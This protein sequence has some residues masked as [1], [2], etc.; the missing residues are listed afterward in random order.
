MRGN[1]ITCQL[2]DWPTIQA[3]TVL[4]CLLILS[5]FLVVLFPCADNIPDAYNRLIMIFMVQLEIIRLFLME[6]I[7]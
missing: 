3:V 1:V 7:A 5:R 2:C 4:I 6:A